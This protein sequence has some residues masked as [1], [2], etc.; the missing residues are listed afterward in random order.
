[1][2]EIRTNQRPNINCANCGAIKK[3]I[4]TIDFYAEG[5]AEKG[6]KQMEF[7]ECTKCKTQGLLTFTPPTEY[8]NLK[9]PLFGEDEYISELLEKAKNL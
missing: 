2:R 8:F 6:D 1:M 3:H 7:L 5:G 4:E 9:G